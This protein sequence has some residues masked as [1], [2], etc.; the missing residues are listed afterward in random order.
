MAIRFLV[1]FFI[2]LKF[3]IFILFSLYSACIPSYIQYP[4]IA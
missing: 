2:L 4:H 3:T 1:F